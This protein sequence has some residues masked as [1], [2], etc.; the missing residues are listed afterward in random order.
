MQVGNRFQTFNQA[1]GF[2]SN[3]LQA[4][5]ESTLDLRLL[6]DL[7]APL[8]EL[9][10][11]THSFRRLAEEM[12]ERRAHREEMASAAAIQR[13]ILPSPALRPSAWTATTRWSSATP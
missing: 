4:L 5:R 2:Y 12:V 8:P 3:A 10:D 9:V 13:T 1:I 7:E 6:H 11:F